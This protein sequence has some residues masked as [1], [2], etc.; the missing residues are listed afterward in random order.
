MSEFEPDF[1]R[2][3][4]PVPPEVREAD[5]DRDR[6]ARDIEQVATAELRALWP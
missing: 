4:D 5:P 2:G 6:R 1:T 3:V